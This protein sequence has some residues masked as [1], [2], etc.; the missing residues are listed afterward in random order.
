[1]KK[2]LK[3]ALWVI[4]G[5]ALV[6]LFVFGRNW[7]LETPLKSIDF[8]L[9][10]SHSKGF[11]EKDSVVSDATAICGLDRHASIGTVDLTKIQK[12]L[13]HNPWIESAS[14]YIGLDETLTINAKEYEPVVRVFNQDNRSVYI[15]KDGVIFPASPVYSPRVIIANG[16]FTFPMPSKNSM[17]SDSVYAHTGLNEALI[18][19]MA[20]N[21]DPFLTKAIGQIFRDENDEYELMVN[22]LPAKVILGNTDAVDNKLSRLATLLKKYNG[23]EELYGYKTLNLKYKNQIVCTKK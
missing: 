13:D 17:V 4:T 18:L 16:T 23:T 22:N 20:I 2:I 7:Y 15:T 1:M 6:A 8:K 5:A 3:I 21:K 12:L 14:A 9:E 19:A 11:V 10:R